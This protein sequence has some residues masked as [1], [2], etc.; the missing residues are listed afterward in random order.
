MGNQSSRISNLLLQALDDL[1]QEDFRRFKDE[2][3]HSDFRGK[4]RIP[5]GRLENADRIDTKNFLMD[6]YGADA[7]V[8]VT[9]EVFTR[10]NLRDAA[11]RLR[12]ERQKALGPDQTHG[13]RAAGM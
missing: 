3:S 1:L 7:A 4:G 13:R 6:F 5:R 2:L 10:V 11:A 9:I 12:E 8:D